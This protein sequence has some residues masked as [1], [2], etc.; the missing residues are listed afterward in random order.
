MGKYKV[1]GSRPTRRPPIIVTPK[2][3]SQMVPLSLRSA[4]RG[5]EMPSPATVVR[6]CHLGNQNAESSCRALV[7]DAAAVLRK[8]PL[9]PNTAVTI[10]PL[11][12]IE[13]P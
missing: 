6:F 12:K 10:G 8:Y 13:S 4:D 9:V 7:D 3:V 2:T 1:L 5:A 11:E